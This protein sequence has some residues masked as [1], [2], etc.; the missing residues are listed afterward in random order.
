MGVYAIKLAE[1]DRVA[2]ACV[3]EPE[4]DLLTITAKGYGKRTPLS[5]FRV[6][7]R[8]GKGIRCMSRRLSRTG[9][10]VAARVVKP[11]EEITIISANGMVLRTNVSD[12]PQMGR[13]TMGAKV[14]DLKKGDEASAIA[15]VNGE[16][17]DAAKSE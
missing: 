3:V 16:N 6:Q 9:P 13:A 14:I 1:N 5:E 10:I 4:A 15:V 8:Y 2:V 7:G 12:I 11:G 17:G